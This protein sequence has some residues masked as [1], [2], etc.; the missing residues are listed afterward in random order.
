MLEEVHSRYGAERV[1]IQSGGTLNGLFIREVN[2]VIAPVIIGGK[3]VATLVD[4]EAITSE[5]ELNKLKALELLECNR[6]EDSYIQL[7]YRVRR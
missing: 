6:L 4:G 5:A 3:D 1:T 2:I 7:K